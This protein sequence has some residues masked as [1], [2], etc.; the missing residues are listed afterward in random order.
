M[1]TGLD[2]EFDLSIEEVNSFTTWYENKQAGSGTASYA[3]DKHDNNKGPFKNR[4]DYVIF[5]KILSFE[6][7]EYTSK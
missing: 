5:D 3:I 6:V 2:K 1:T 7:N 4:K